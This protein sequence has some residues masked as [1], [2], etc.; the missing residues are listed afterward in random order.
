MASRDAMLKMQVYSETSPRAVHSI[1]AL[2]TLVVRLL[3]MHILQMLEQIHRTR[4]L[5]IATNTSFHRRGK[6]FIIQI[7]ILVHIR[8]EVLEAS[9]VVVKLVMQL[10]KGLGCETPKALTAL[11]ER[12]STDVLELCV[13]L[14]RQAVVEL[15]TA[16]GA[17]DQALHLVDLLDVVLEELEPLVG[18]SA[19]VT[20]VSGR[21]EFMLR[22]NEKFNL[23]GIFL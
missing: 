14:E 15:F 17:L 3:I 5:Q 18:D 11:V 10:H 21:K 4:K 9:G 20:R 2:A 8:L 16:L 13:F 6:L 23:Q 7:Q 1:V 12:S 22:I 19:D